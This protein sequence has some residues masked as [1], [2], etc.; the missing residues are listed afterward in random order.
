MSTPDGI[1]LASLLTIDV[2]S[3]LRKLSQ[4]QLQGPW[5]IP[6]ELARRALRDGA[7]QVE[8]TTGRSSVRVVDRGAPIDP[9]ILQATAAVLEPTQ[10]NETRHAALTTLEHA[11]GLA[12]LAVAGL[13]RKQLHIEVR[14]KEARYQLRA[15]DRQA[16]LERF[17]PEGRVG[18]E[19][20]V[21]SPELD[22]RQVIHWLGSVARFASG[23]VLVDG[24]PIAS[25]FAG[26][27][28]HGPLRSPTPGRAAI[29]RDGETAHLWLLEHGIITGHLTVP[30]APAFEAAIEMGSDATDLSAARLRESITPHISHLVDCAVGLACHL[31]GRA[32]ELSE[33]LRGRVSRLLLVAAR[34][35]VRVRDVAEVAT[36]RVVDRQGPSLASLVQLRAACQSGPAGA[37]TLP[38]L[39]PS[40]KPNKFALGTGPTLVAD[41]TERSAL[42]EVLG[43]RFRPPNPRDGSSSMRAG[44]LR[45]LHGAGR[46]AKRFTEFVRHPLGAR[47]LP[48]ASLT[49]AERTFVDIL[50]SHLNE[51]APDGVRTVRVCAGTGPIRR[52]SGQE[53]ALLLPRNNPTVL[54]AIA[55]VAHH[56]S[57]VYPVA[58]ALLE[59]KG[60]PS[61]SSQAQWRDAL[62]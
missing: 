18:N 26:A 34:R 61:S 9:R 41:A 12:L 45:R 25:G 10:S 60:L 36:F 1:D 43:I 28:I 2:G 24:Q 11:G 8:I 17:P 52:T 13:P 58:L 54:A 51:G 30:D 31:G 42:A 40:Q 44:L 32:S 7:P 47:P 49:P 38:A 29:L 59:G 21:I 4:A 35:R 50:G 39:Y 20:K 53:R 46:A 33:P 22:K 55:A 57:W 3:E 6:A 16:R 48:L 56:P 62:R 19:I 15:N 27:L 14:T 37:R 23:R 5:Q